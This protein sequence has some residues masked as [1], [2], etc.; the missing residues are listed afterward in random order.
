MKTKLKSFLVIGIVG[1]LSIGGTSAQNAMVE[2]PIISVAGKN[3]PDTLTNALGKIQKVELSQRHE[4]LSLAIKLT[5]VSGT[6]TGKVILQKSNDGFLWDRVGGLDSLVFT[7]AT[8]T[9]GKNFDIPLPL[10]YK[11]IRAV[12]TSTGTQS[13][14]LDSKAY[15]KVKY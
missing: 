13:S 7:A 8:G 2:K 9:I 3:T 6:V 4:T 14:L 12:W 5:R 15:F 1:L 10:A 11:F